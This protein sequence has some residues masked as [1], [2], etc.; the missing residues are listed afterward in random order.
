MEE[1]INEEGDLYTIDEINQT[2]KDQNT[3][4]EDIVKRNN[5]ALNAK[6]EKPGKPKPVAKKDVP[7]TVK[8]TASKSVKPSSASRTSIW[9]EDKSQPEFVTKLQD[10]TQAK[11]T[12]I[13]KPGYKYDSRGYLVPKTTKEPSLWD[14]TVDF[15]KN[16]FADKTPDTDGK[17]SYYDQ[18]PIKEQQQS[19][20][21]DS[22]F[23]FEIWY[24]TA[25]SS[26]VINIVFHV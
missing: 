12:P 22:N 8:N 26:S 2:A 5:L 16:L 9:G 20:K 14:D 3:T 25:I 11:V 24:F 21:L 4:F 17:L 19:F 13:A 18:K 15:A 6:K 1:Y 23:R 10:T 7:V